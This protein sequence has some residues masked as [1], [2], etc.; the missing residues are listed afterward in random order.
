MTGVPGL[1]APARLLVNPAV[2]EIGARVIGLDLSIVST[3][4]ALPDGTTGRIK[5]RTGDRDRRLV[6]I[7][8]RVAELV[9]EHRPDLAVIEDMP[10]RM[11]ATA[12]KA[13]GRVH[14]A[15]NT[16][17]LDADVPY[18]YVPPA[19]L[20]KYAT[21]NGNAPK[22]DMAAA[23]FLAAGAHFPDDP[24]G[25]R[26]DAWWLRASG[27]DA[28]GVPLFELPAAQRERLAKVAWPDLTPQRYVLGLGQ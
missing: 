22:E 19:T 27:H 15:V 8:D 13:I 4:Y 20:K 11:K 1:L 26:C 21:D 14:G 24:K 2:L 9:A 28:Y 3:G 5:T 16:A 25:D 10:T 7:R 6:I 23:A 18:A 17:L 12:V